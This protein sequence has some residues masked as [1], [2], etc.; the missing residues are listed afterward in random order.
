MSGGNP[1][2][3]PGMGYVKHNPGSNRSGP[4][5][6]EVAC[7]TTCGEVEL[8]ITL[9][10][11]F[12]AKTLRDALI[13][14]FLK[15]HN[16]RA[17]AP[18]TFDQIKCLKIDGITLDAEAVFADGAPDAGSLLT[19]EAVSVLLLT[20]VPGTLLESVLEVAREF[21]PVT[22]ENYQSPPPPPLTKQL[23]RIAEQAGADALAD[24]SDVDDGASV[25]SNM[26]SDA[27][28]RCSNAFQAV[29]G[30]ATNV[31]SVH[32]RT[33]LLHDAHVR[34]LCFPPTSP[35]IPSIDNALRRMAVDR[36]A[37][38]TVESAEFTAFFA[39]LSAIA[40]APTAFGKEEPEEQPAGRKKKDGGGGD[41]LQSLLD[42]DSV[43]TRRIA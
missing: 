23:V 42:D 21:E 14:P 24:A 16:K 27:S 33:A 34:S 5:I 32:V 4:A 43:T 8:K 41:F 39:A 30:G 37:D 25:V 36:A 38:P 7:R 35:H 13:E 40:C 28:R 20:S 17:A 3:V 22:Y 18:V 10:R 31:S 6:S 15:V 11:K 9:N 29:G 1:H 12:L 26:D 2:Y 19:K